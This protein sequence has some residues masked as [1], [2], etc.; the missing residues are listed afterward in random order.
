MLMTN[1]AMTLPDLSGW[2]KSDVL[3]LAELTGLKVTF[4]GE[5]FVSSQDLPVHSFIE[6]Q[7]ELVVTL[8]ANQ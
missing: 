2:S 6:S 1:G 8:S 3:R 7:T 5:G 4:E